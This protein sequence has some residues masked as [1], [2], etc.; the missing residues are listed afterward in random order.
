MKIV[1]LS[2]GSKGNV[3]YLEIRDK[4]FLLDAGRNYK[5]INENL[6]KIDVDIKDI[7]YIVI[8]HN[9]SDHVSGLEVILKKTN[10]T[11]IVSQ[12]LFYS[13]DNKIAYEHVII[14]EEEIDLDGVHITSFKSSHDA[15]DA[16]N[17]VFEYDGKK[18]CYVT[19]TGYLKQ[20]YFKILKNLD[21]YLFE[22]NHDLELLMN[23]PY[24]E[25]L[26]RRVSSDDGHLSNKMAAFYLTK[27]VGNK[28]KKIVLIHLSETN[29]M[30]D[31][32]LE[33][34]KNTFLEYDIKFND[35]ICAR[36]EEMTEVI[37]I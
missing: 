27:L 17:Y 35:I 9:H 23:G 29:N 15:P 4:K 25:F 30:E 12:E 36:Q 28:T 8:T 24:P 3:T 7:N 22:S 20:K 34:I 31:I 16:R 6:S 11:L 13:L 18:V 5:Y 37:E 1:V 26:K 19:D 32:A 14:F 2:S 10:A 21:V 33:T